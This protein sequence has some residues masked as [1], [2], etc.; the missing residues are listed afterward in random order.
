[1]ADRTPRAIPIVVGLVTPLALLLTNTMW[2]YGGI[3]LSIAAV[4]WIGFAA[5]LL[6]PS[7]ST[8]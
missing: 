1:M 7:G 2:S 3:L 6:A 8:T 5:V 4:V